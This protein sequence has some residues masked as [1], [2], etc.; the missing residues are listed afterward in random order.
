LADFTV[1]AAGTVGGSTS[2]KADSTTILADN[3]TI[4]A[5]AT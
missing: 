5:D 3:S 2:I 4:K 1:T